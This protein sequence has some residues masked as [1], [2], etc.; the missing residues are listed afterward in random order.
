ML[1]R[2]CVCMLTCKTASNCKRLASTIQCPFAVQ[3][4]PA[5]LAPVWVHTSSSRRHHQTMSYA[6]HPHMTGVQISLLRLMRASHSGNRLELV[7]SLTPITMR[8]YSTVLPYW[9]LL[10]DAWLQACSG[11]HHCF[12]LPQYSSLVCHRATCQR[13]AC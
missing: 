2:A 7:F 3:T 11:K 8:A 1:Y 5:K 12:L 6:N 4:G 10:R 13:I 9:S